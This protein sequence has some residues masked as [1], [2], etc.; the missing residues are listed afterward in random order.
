MKYLAIPLAMLATGS[1]FATQTVS[2]SVEVVA[3]IPTEAFYV[4]QD[5]NWIGLPQELVYN[6]VTGAL[7]PVENR[8]VAK[9]STGAIE[10][11]LD[12]PA[13][14][15]SGSSRINLNVSVNGVELDV[16]NKEIVADTEMGNQVFMPIRIAA[17]PAPVNGYTA[18]NYAGIVNMTFET[19]L[20]APIP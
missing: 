1:A 17:A 8:L 11:R 20:T 3:N 4:E 9:S 7:A 18:G 13:E 15:T 10:A 19:P 5:G 2:K 12:H 14:I 16:S 6:T